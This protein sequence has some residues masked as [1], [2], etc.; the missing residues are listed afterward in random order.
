MPH[1]RDT[2]STDRS[3][4]WRSRSFRSEHRSKPH[5]LGR[6]PPAPDLL[7]HEAHVGIHVGEHRLVAGAKMVVPAV[8]DPVNT[9]LGTAT[10]AG[11]APVA[12]DAVGCSSAFIMPKACCFP[13]V[14]ERGES[15][16]PPNRSAIA[17]WVRRPVLKSFPYQAA[18][19]SP[20]FSL[21]VYAQLKFVS[22]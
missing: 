8:P 19:G 18:G 22:L 15:V 11:E 9:V 4:R 17:A 10:L 13:A 6:R 5:H 12:A 14:D 21:T 2:L 7:G 3:S 20:S 16:P 1:H